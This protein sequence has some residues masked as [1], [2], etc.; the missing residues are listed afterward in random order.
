MTTQIN[1]IIR[2]LK[3]RKRGI[4]SKEAIDKY[5]CTRLSAVIN[6]IEKKGYQIE[7]QRERVT[8]RYGTTTIVRYWMVDD[9]LDN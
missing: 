7:K 3:T 6:A 2:H 8:T 1:T 4:T 5:G 9:G